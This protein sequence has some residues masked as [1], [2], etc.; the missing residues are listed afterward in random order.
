MGKDTNRHM[1]ASSP[2]PPPANQKR[3]SSCAKVK[4]VEEFSGRA[5]CDPCRVHKRRKCAAKMSDHRQTLM[6]LREEKHDLKYQLADSESKLTVS[7]QE[8][9]RLTALLRT[10]AASALIGH[11]AVYRHDSPFLSVEGP[12]DYSS[13]G[14]SSEATQGSAPASLGRPCSGNGMPSQTPLLAYPGGDYSSGEYSSEGTQGSAPPK[15]RRPCL[16]NRAP[17]PGNSCDLNNS[18]WIPHTEFT[19]SRFLPDVL[20]PNDQVVLKDQTEHQ[21]NYLKR[22]A[23]T[24]SVISPSNTEWQN[25]FDAKLATFDSFPKHSAGQYMNV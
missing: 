7:Q 23:P 20:A 25:L 17:P 11:Q 5:T 16:G 4:A 6:T 9:A 3:C 1:S 19:L 14:Y 24:Q 8:V 12:P 21:T 13:A 10:Y 18:D 2:S 15:F 22:K